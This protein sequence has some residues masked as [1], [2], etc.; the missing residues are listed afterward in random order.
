MEHFSWLSEQNYQVLIDH[1]QDGIFVIEDEKFTYANQRL[2]T[3]FGYP[4]EE[5]IGRPFIEM[6]ADIDKSMVLERHHARLAGETV[7]EL[8][9]IRIFTKQGTMIYCSLNIGL[10][11]SEDGHTVAVGSLRD[12]TQQ[13]NALAELQASKEELNSIFEHLP[14][15]F[16]RT[17][18][19]G[20]IT[21]ISPS[22][23]DLLGYR[24]DEILGT[25]MTS[26]YESPEARQKVVE[27]IIDGGGKATKVESKLKHKDGSI[28]WVSTSAYTCIGPDGTP[29]CIEGMARDIS[30]RKFMEEQL[31]ALSRTDA[32]TGIYTRRYFMDTS[33]EA[34]KAMRRYKHSVSMI[35]ADLDN[36]KKINDK[37]GHHA[38]DLALIAFTEECRKEIRD[39]DIFGRLGGEEFSLVLPETS[40]EQAKIL[41]ERIRKATAAIEVTVDGQVIKFTVSIGLAEIGK[42][43][44]SL[45]SAMH[46]ADL[47]M[48]HAKE[49]GRNRVVVS[50]DID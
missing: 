11:K 9:N 5:L 28:I 1:L 33:E 24:P 26:Y 19:H 20:F 46:R 36:F 49:M 3:M 21:R 25:Q 32:L 42:E 35:V 7:P 43:D 6:V 37:Y 38:G 41:A 44:R 23:F 39:A 4:L 40:I 10:S 2:A 34:V 30:E 47:A 22:C 12:V 45:E 27:A 31:I 8:Y 18:M 29:S 13:Q 14:D 48:Y 16:Y 50:P 15:V 17:N